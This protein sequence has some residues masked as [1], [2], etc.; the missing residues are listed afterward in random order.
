GDVISSLKIKGL[1]EED[2]NIIQL[3]IGGLIIAEEVSAMF[4]SSDVKKRLADLG[5]SFGRDG[6]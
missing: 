2:E 3:T 5:N 1:I 4:Y 6:L